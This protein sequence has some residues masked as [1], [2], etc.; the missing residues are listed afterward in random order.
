MGKLEEGQKGH[1]ELAWLGKPGKVTKV[2]HNCHP[3]RQVRRRRWPTAAG[4][5]EEAHISTPQGFMDRV[6]ARERS[7]TY[8]LF[9]PFAG[10]APPH[11]VYDSKI[12]AHHPALVFLACPALSHRSLAQSSRL[13]WNPSFPLGMCRLFQD[14]GSSYPVSASL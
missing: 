6:L 8:S 10:R 13:S 11:T 7:G 1:H 3:G 4:Q 5:A 14:S 2:A 9:N 12:P